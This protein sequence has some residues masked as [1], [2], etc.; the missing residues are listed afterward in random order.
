MFFNNY[1][2]NIYIM[3]TYTTYLYHPT[4][5]SFLLRNDLRFSTPSQRCPGPHFAAPVPVPHE[6]EELPEME[7]ELEE[8]DGFDFRFHW[9]EK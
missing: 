6:G 5:R 9:P 7:E 3:F 2:H 8:A 4:F 1:R